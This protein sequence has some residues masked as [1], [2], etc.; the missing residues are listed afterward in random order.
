MSG[1]GSVVFRLLQENRKLNN[2]LFAR[3]PRSGSGQAEQM[4]RAMWVQFMNDFDFYGVPSVETDWEGR[5][6]HVQYDPT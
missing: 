4:Q 3:L 5:E 2:K 6:I 1:V